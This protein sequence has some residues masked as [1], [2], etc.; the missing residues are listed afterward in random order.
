M[1]TTIRAF[2]AVRVPASPALRDVLEE[3]GQMGRPIKPVDSDHLHVTLRFLGETHEYWIHRLRDFL[4][5]VS[6]QT[7]SFDIKLRGLGAFPKPS[8]SSVIWAGIAHEKPIVQLAE[9]TENTMMECGFAAGSRPF[10]PHVTLARVKA[11][12][13]SRLAA[14]LRAHPDTEFGS[15][16]VQEIILMQSQLSPEGPTYTPLHTFPLV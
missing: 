3:L 1:S 9:L 10:K 8:Y 12:P 16:R 11:R 2:V 6:A 4:D 13:P 7:D 5:L 14:L 15:L